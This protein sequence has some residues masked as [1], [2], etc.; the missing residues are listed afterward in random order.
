M[1]ERIKMQVREVIQAGIMPT[2]VINIAC[3]SANPHPHLF[4]K[5]DIMAI[6][7][8]VGIFIILELIILLFMKGTDNDNDRR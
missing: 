7:G 8:L 5:G 2:G 3:E 6:V 4:K 1:T